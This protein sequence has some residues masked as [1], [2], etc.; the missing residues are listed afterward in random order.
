MPRK[1]KPNKHKSFLN[2]LEAQKRQIQRENRAR[3]QDSGV[4]IDLSEDF[5]PPEP[6]VSML[7]RK[8]KGKRGS[9]SS[10]RSKPPHFTSET[11]TEIRG[12]EQSTKAI[13]KGSY[14]HKPR[15][16]NSR[17]ITVN[18]RVTKRRAIMC[19]DG[20]LR[21]SVRVISR[22]KSEKRVWV[23]R[24]GNPHSKF[25]RKYTRYLPEKTYQVKLRPEDRY[26]KVRD[27]ALV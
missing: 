11:K 19:D 15:K 13:T 24:N 5:T 4:K 12:K 9:T 20:L 8:V 18:R 22:K 1:R 7:T 23:N 3:L 27:Y 25:E 2:K 10:P 14:R 17:F 6:E 26:K 21:P 16:S